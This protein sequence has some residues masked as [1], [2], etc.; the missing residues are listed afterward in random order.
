MP[1]FRSFYRAFT[2]GAGSRID[3]DVTDTG[4]RILA[5]GMWNSGVITE[6]ARYSFYKAFGYT[7]ADQ[8]ALED[9]YDTVE[10]QWSK[11]LCVKLFGA[12]THASGGF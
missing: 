7:P 11:P 8:R 10:M 5:R 9:Y 1:I 3:K 2:R 12:P 6:A 4:F